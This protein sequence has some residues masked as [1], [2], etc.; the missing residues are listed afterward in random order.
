VTAIQ[1]PVTPAAA[2]DQPYEYARAELVE[3]D[4]RRFPGWHDVT[5]AQWRDAQWQR[6]HCSPTSASWRRCRCCCRRR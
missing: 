3:P 5:D 6:V 2:I 4:W 1:E